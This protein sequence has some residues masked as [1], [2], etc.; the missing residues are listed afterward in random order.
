MASKQL[1]MTVPDVLNSD[2]DLP[3][4]IFFHESSE[5]DDLQLN[6]RER[7][8]G[9]HRFLYNL[10]ILSL[11]C[12]VTLSSLTQ[13]LAYFSAFWQNRKMLTFFFFFRVLFL[14]C[15]KCHGILT[16]QVFC[17][18]ILISP[19]PTNLLKLKSGVHLS[20][21]TEYLPV[22]ILRKHKYTSLSYLGWKWKHTNLTSW[23]M[24]DDRSQDKSRT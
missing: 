3:V 21:D 2:F 24:K 14:I 10:V 19:L 12:Q 20:C 9:R 22:L 16:H 5:S 15:A 23:P 13:Q 7:E 17:R 4:G 6:K 11:H 8:N 18:M 1:V